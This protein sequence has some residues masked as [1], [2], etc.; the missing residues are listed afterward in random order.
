M[1]LHSK[2]WRSMALFMSLS[3]AKPRSVDR[4]RGL[5]WFVVPEK[6]AC[7]LV[8]IVTESLAEL[9][10]KLSHAE[11]CDHVATPRRLPGPRATYPLTGISL[12]R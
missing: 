3:E 6:G 4:S 11:S 7:K 5:S 9:K 10:K 2:L 12:I 8:R 1:H